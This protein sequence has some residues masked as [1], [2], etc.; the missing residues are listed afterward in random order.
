MKINNILHFN[1]CNI[2]GISFHLTNAKRNENENEKR[3]DRLLSSWLQ[4]LTSRVRHR[5]NVNNSEWPQKTKQNKMHGRENDDEIKPMKEE[6]KQEEK[7]DENFN[8]FVKCNKSIIHF[9][10]ETMA[11]Y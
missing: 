9:E 7:N 8:L 5:R 10:M 4:C 11:P 1:G 2:F 6:K 3:F